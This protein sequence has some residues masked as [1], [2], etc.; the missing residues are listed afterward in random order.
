MIQGKSSQGIFSIDFLNEQIGMA[1]GGD[2]SKENEG[3][4]NIIITED[5]GTSW[6]LIS[7]SLDFRSCIKFVGKYTVVT[8]PS[9]S[10]ISENLGKSW[11][12]IDGFG[13]HTLGVDDKSRTV[14]AAGSDG[15]VGRFRIE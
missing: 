7:P 13:F 14:W 11:L 1:V 5:G 8:G 9:G 6:S 10:E 12:D 4:D 3:S 15:R 2:Y